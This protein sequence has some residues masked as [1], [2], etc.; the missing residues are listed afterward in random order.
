MYGLVERARLQG[1]EKSLGRA[2]AFAAKSM[3]N[4]E[5]LAL[6]TCGAACWL[7]GVQPGGRVG[8]R[9]ALWGLDSGRWNTVYD[10][11]RRAA[12]DASSNGNAAHNLAFALLAGLVDSRIIEVGRPSLA[13]TAAAFRN[14]AMAF[15]EELTNTALRL[16]GVE[17]DIA[18]HDSAPRV[19][20]A[21]LASERLA[22]LTGA[23]KAA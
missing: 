10:H 20:A 15:A 16:T 4:A 2:V 19:Q 8:V 23:A 1:H 3:S 18:A 5:L 21:A 14:R 9:S 12:R 13:P 7:A 22:A 17:A 11:L 6:S